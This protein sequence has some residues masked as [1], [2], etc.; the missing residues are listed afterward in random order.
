MPEDP[1]WRKKFAA[2]TLISLALFFVIFFGAQATLNHTVN[3]AIQDEAVDHAR[4]V[5]KDVQRNFPEIERIA[6]EGRA[7]VGTLD[8]LHA[9]LSNSDGLQQVKIYN[10]EGVLRYVYDEDLWIRQGGHMS[11]PELDRSRRTQAPIF[12]PLDLAPKNGVTPVVVRTVEPVF[13]AE[14]NLIAFVEV[15]MDHSEAALVFRQSFDWLTIALPILMALSYLVPTL[16]WLFLKSRHG[17]TERMVHQLSRRDRLTGLMNRATFTEEAFAV[18]KSPATEPFKHGLMIVDINQFRSVNEVHGHRVGDAFL[19]HVAE[20]LQRALREDDLVAR[21]NG[22][23]FVAVLP[24]V[25]PDELARAANRVRTQL[26][27]QFQHDE[28]KLTCQACIGTH[29][30]NPHDTLD[31][32][33]QAADLALTHAKESGTDLVVAYS[34]DLDRKRARRRMIE[35]T[36]RDAWD[37]GRAHLVFQPVIDARS[38]RIAGFETLLRLTTDEG[39][40]ISPAEFIPIAEQTG[41]IREL[42]RITIQKALQAALAWPEDTF[43]AINLSPAQFRH[44]DLVDDVQWLIDTTGFPPSR[45]E[46]EITESLLLDEEPEVR[47][48]FDG[49]KALGTSI[50][51]DDFGTGYSSLSYL[52]A[53]DFDKL[54][55]DRTFLEDLR[56]NPVRQRKILKS[57][58]DLG[59]QIGLTVTMEGLETADQVEMLDALGCDLFQ[60]FYFSRPVAETEIRPILE[61]EAGGAA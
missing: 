33:M 32:A 61:R 17:Q 43:L 36:L 30:A 22:D 4:H 41:Q 60:G 50:A 45:L 39:E 6:R 15:T 11:T 2:V 28:I 20:I 9:F 13:D 48:Q 59:Q 55:I 38:R 58:V 57:I 34:A 5:T 53:H 26:R 23:E 29:L 56:S 27:R 31:D 42:G 21:F 52:L 18:F 49:L 19:C 44:G 3:R 16:A 54:K 7:D 14:G 47:A 10:H 12:Q 37:N 1:D 25:L 51:M 8:Q 40:P 35:A 24:S 46:F